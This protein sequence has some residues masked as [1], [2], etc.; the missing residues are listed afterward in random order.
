MNVGPDA[1][2]VK[3]RKCEGHG[4]GGAMARPH[5]RAMVFGV[6]RGMCRPYV[7]AHAAAPLTSTDTACPRRPR[8]GCRQNRR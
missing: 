4:A 1:F 7:P 2:H 5:A 3:L 8:A 6:R